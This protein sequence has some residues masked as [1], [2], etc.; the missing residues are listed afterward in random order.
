MSSESAQ[1][2]AGARVLVTGAT[3]FIGRPLVGALLAAGARVSALVLPGEEAL[4]SPGVRAFCGDVADAALLQ[5]AV[6]E[7]QPD[8][9]FHLAA[10]GL[11]QPNLPAAEA[12]RVN[13]GGTVALLEALREMGSARRLVLAGSAYEY[14]A[15]RADDSLDP[16]NA[17]AASKVA[18]WA[19][20]RAAYNTWGAPVVWARPFQVYG[21]GQPEQAFIP[22]ALRAALRG[23][24]FPMT[25]GEQQRDFIFVDDVV[26]GLLALAQAEGIAGRAFDLGTGVL[27]TLRAVAERIWVLTGARGSLLPGALPYRP[28]EVPAIPADPERARRL[29]GWQARVTLEAGLQKLIGMSHNCPEKGSALTQSC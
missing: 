9:V 12:L 8:V 4:L 26:A 21:P 27:H 6:A 7:S 28:G 17:Y 16:F 14:G 10:V 25:G 11:T 2:L 20:A 1:G 23:D 29:I 19:F 18:A 15:R 3:G 24:D 22:A 13:V 5:R